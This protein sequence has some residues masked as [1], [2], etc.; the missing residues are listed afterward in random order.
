MHS[1]M[2]LC[3]YL[4]V[5]SLLVCILYN[6]CPCSSLMPIA[7]KWCVVR[8]LILFYVYLYNYIYIYI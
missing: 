2:Y 7:Y 8:I 1:Y 3:V 5:F 4:R 6:V